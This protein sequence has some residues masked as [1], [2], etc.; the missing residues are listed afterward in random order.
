VCSVVAVLRTIMIGGLDQA[1]AVRL[2]ER[3]GW[4]GVGMDPV[5]LVAMLSAGAT[6]AAG[7]GAAAGLSELVKTG[8]VDAYT[9]C[10]TAVR[11]RF[12]DDEDAKEKLGQLEVKPDDPALQTVLAGY[13]EKHRAGEDPAVTQAAESLRVSLARIEGGIGSITIRDI[14]GNTITADRGGIAAA[15][16]T[17]G[18][19]AGYTPQ[20]D[21]DPR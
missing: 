12:G 10:K 9:A 7:A 2:A 13:L 5:S 3:M 8:I 17:G 6:V 21:A 14:T 20:G 1:S 19:T 15:T 11:S 16:I 4:G 18:A